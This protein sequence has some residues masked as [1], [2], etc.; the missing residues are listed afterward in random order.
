MIIKCILLAALVRLLIAT[1]K[2]FLCSGLYAVVPLLLGLAMQRPWERLLTSAGVVFI[3]ASIYFW[4]L[5]R[6]D[7]GSAV[8]W[9]IAIAGIALGFV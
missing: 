1:E 5:N 7:E 4:L 3:L 8:W 9:V 6:L 2:P